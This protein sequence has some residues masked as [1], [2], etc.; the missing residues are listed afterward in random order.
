MYNV[1]GH[2]CTDN[3]DKPE[4]TSKYLKYHY[5][6]IGDPGQQLSFWGHQRTFLA[7]FWTF[8]PHFW[9]LLGPPWPLSPFWNR[10]K[11][12]SREQSGTSRDFWRCYF[13][14]PHHMAELAK[15]SRRATGPYKCLWQLFMLYLQGFLFL[16][17]QNSSI[18]DLVTD[19][20]Q[21]PQM[22]ARNL[23]ITARNRQ[24]QT[25]NHI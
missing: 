10:W 24:I 2:P 8:Q 1:H 18:G 16:A 22:N 4:K 14:W 5:R 7:Q 25:R 17:V 15:L 20:R 19:N 21:E 11:V 6:T 3:Y 9:E 13:Q 12:S 23:H